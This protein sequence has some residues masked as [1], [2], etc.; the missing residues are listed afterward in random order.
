MRCCPASLIW[1]PVKRICVESHSILSPDCQEYKC[2]NTNYQP[3][4]ECADNDI[5]ACFPFTTSYDDMSRERMATHHSNVT[6][7]NGM[8]HF[9]GSESY[10]RIPAFKNRFNGRRITQF[11]IEVRFQFSAR[12]YGVQGLVYKGDCKVGNSPTFAILLNVTS[13]GSRVEAFVNDKQYSVQSQVSRRP[14][15]LSDRF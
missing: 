4:T 6:L 8:A 1:N 11:S 14:I 9:P 2:R 3:P 12:R 13:H 7:N 5:L 10:L 15:D